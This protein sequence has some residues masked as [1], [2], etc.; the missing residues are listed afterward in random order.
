MTFYYK[1]KIEGVVIYFLESGD[2]TLM[3]I[4]EMCHVSLKTIRKI[5]NN[6]DMF[7]AK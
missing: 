4:A 5:V 3:Q 2:Y 7:Y 1:Q 6:Y